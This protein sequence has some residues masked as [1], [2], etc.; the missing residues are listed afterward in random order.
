[1]RAG[2]DQREEDEEA[3]CRERRGKLGLEREGERESCC[4]A[5][6]DQRLQIGLYFLVS[7]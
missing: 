3:V 5:N 6:G 4:C 7:R 1:M 2:G